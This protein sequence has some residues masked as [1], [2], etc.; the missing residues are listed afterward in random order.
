MS[1]IHQNFNPYEKKEFKALFIEW[2]QNELEEAFASFTNEDD[3]IEWIEHSHFFTD[4]ARKDAVRILY[5]RL[6]GIPKH[7][8]RTAQFFSIDPKTVYN[9]TK[10]EG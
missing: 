5:D 6:N 1:I 9:Y 2:F 3:L 7:T 4:D 8:K 10:N